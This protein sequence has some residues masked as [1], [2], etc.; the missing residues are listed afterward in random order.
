MPLYDFE[1]C[2]CGKKFESISKP[3]DPVI[4]PHCGYQKTRRLPSAVKVIGISPES[5]E[6]KRRE[7]K[8][9]RV[10]KLY[11]RQGTKF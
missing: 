4:C 8:R 9:E 6:M 2:E 1:C 10:A 3:W 11:E 7:A 5:K